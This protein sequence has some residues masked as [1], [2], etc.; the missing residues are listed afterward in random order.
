MA[1]ML[2]VDANVVSE[3]LDFFVLIAT[4]TQLLLGVSNLSCQPPD[5]P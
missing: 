1:M 4:H 5:E 2:V 3:I